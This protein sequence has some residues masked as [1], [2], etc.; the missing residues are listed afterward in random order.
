MNTFIKSV[1]CSLLFAV[2]MVSLTDAQQIQPG[3]R[4]YRVIAY[5]N[6]NPSVTSMSNTTE[7]IP[8]MSIYI[9]NSFTPNGDGMND[10]FGVYGEAIKN[11]KMQVFNRWG[12]VI[13]ESNNANNRW[14]GTF[15]GTQVPE[16]TYAYRVMATGL[17]GK[18]STKDG[19]VNLIY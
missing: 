16:G 13:F 7:V 15:E 8:Y 1:I 2:L 11:F 14:D 4:R 17:T 10:T 6:G 19:T 12:Q 9:P 3:S 18:S 5:K